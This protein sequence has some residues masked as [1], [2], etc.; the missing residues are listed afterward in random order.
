MPTKVPLHF[1]AEVKAGLEADVKKGVL[2]WVHSRKS[3]RAHRNVDMSGLSRACR[4]ESHHSRS[5]AEI[6]KLVPAG[7]LNSTMHCVDRYH[8]VELAMENRH[9]TTFATE[10]GLFRYI[11]VPQGYISSGDIYTNQTDA[12][13]EACPGKPENSDYENIMDDTDKYLQ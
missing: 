4:Q 3:G 9:K 12:I 1:R 8:K 6:A 2:E 10:W 5:A 13:L 11:R 7:K